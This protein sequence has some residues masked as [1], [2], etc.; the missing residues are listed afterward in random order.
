MKK[1]ELLKLPTI[2]ATRSMMK[3]AADDVLKREI[4]RYYAGSYSRDSYNIGLYMRCR[5]IG[6]VLKVAFFLTENMRSGGKLPAYELYIDRK[7]HD[8]IT[9]DRDQKKWLTAKLDMIRWPSYVSNSKS[10]WISQKGHETIMTFLG[11]KQG[12]YAGILANCFNKP[13]INDSDNTYSD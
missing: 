9:Y 10:K 6:S 3:M 1:Q 12:G 11:T 7:N 2:K 8:F 5:I 4:V 13:Y